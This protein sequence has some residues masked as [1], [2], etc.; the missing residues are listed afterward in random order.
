M[1]HLFLLFSTLTINSIPTQI[2]MSPTTG[3]PCYQR[4]WAHA[5]P[6]RGW[7]SLATPSSSCP[8]SSLTFP[9]CSLWTPARTSSPR[10]RWTPWRPACLLSRAFTW[11]TTRW[12]RRPMKHCWRWPAARWCSPLA[13]RR[14]GRTSPSE[15]WGWLEQPKKPK[16]SPGISLF[17]RD[18]RS[19]A[20]TTSVRQILNSCDIL[21]IEQKPLVPQVPY[22]PNLML[23]DLTSNITKYLTSSDMNYLAL[24]SVCATY[25]P[26]FFCVYNLSDWFQR[27][28]VSQVK[29]KNAAQMRAPPPPIW[30]S[31]LVRNRLLVEMDKPSQVFSAPILQSF[32]TL[33]LSYHSYS[34]LFFPTSRKLHFLGPPPRDMFHFRY[35]CKC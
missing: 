20:Y 7:T 30:M 2:W 10:S 4:S 3:S 13:R 19:L 23:F 6:W 21:Y 29:I 11:R 9:S 26:G 5:L 28:T 32:P 17:Y 31:T 33:S 12:R 22:T 16:L 1:I 8:P 35:E 15:A 18:F 34:H 24:L 27:R 25:A 14:T